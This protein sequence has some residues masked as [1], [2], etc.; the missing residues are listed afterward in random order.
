MNDLHKQVHGIIAR[1]PD[2]IIGIAAGTAGGMVVAGT[3]ATL[4]ALSSIGGT[5]ALGSSA[6]IVAFRTAFAAACPVVAPA[7]ACCA[8]YGAAK[9]TMN[10]VSKGCKVPKYLK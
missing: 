3:G 8:V 4:A 2:P 5:A 6:G 9:G 1:S 10:W 7:I